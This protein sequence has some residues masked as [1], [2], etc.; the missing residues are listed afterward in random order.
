M[1]Q[2]PKSGLGRLFVEVSILHTIRHTQTPSSTALDKRSAHRS[3]R[4]LHKPAIAAIKPM[5]TYSLG[6]SVTGIG[7]I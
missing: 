6:R 1:A 3:G 4:Y 7:S 5:Q 2:Q